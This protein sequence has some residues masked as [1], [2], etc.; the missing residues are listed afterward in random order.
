MHGSDAAHAFGRIAGVRHCAARLL[1]VLHERNQQRLRADIEQAFDHDHIVPRRPDDGC[2]RRAGNRAEDVGH[3]RRID[4]R[5]LGVDDQKIESGAA[6]RFGCRGGSADQPRAVR[7]RTGSQR[8][9]ERI[10]GH[11]HDGPSEHGALDCSGRD[12]AMI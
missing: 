6:E 4:R 2:G 12:L 8:A 1:R 10:D 7:R 3:L 9:L 11:V 5:V